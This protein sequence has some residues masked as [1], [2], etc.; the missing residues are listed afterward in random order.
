MAAGKRR[1][2]GKGR[3]PQEPGIP[4]CP[5]GD[6]P[7]PEGRVQGFKRAPLP[8]R[9]LRRS[10]HT[11]NKELCAANEALRFQGEEL[12]SVGAQ[13]RARIK[14]LESANNDLARFF[15]STGIPVLFLDREFNV[16]RFTPA[17]CGLAEFQQ[18]DIGRPLPDLLLKKLGAGLLH[19]AGAV[20]DCPDPRSRK[21]TIGNV[22]YVRT[23]R[24]YRTEDNR[25]EGSV[26]TFVDI[27]GCKAD[28][29][30]FQASE[31]RLR[32]LNDSGLLGVIYWDIDGV[33][34][35]ANDKFLEMVGHSRADLDAGI[36]DWRRLTPPEYRE[37]D[38]LS[39]IELKLTGLNRTSF[40]KE[41][42]RKDGSRI[43]VIV[44]G[45]MLDEER[46]S[47]VAV[48]LDNT[49]RKRAEE[50]L[51]ESEERYR[52]LF[53]TL[54]EGFC[55][56]QMI[57]DSTGKPVDYRYLQ[58]NAAFEKQTGLHEA[59]GKL[60]RDLA[61]NHE[62]HW[63]EIYGTIALTGVRRHFVNQARALNRWFDVYAYRVGNPENRQVAILFNDISGIKGSEEILRSQAA[64]LNQAHDA[65][66]VR[67]TGERI[68][69]WNKGAEAMYGWP[70]REALGAHAHMLLKTRFPRP[71]EEI[72]QE[73]AEKGAW[74]GELIHTCR[75]GREIVVDSRWVAHKDNEGHRTGF[76][77]LNRD[78]TVRKLA[79]EALK[80][81][82]A[83]LEA[84][85]AELDSFNYSV[86]HDL[87]G[88]L[89]AIGAFG[90]MLGDEYR[91]L[92]DGSGKV[93]LEQIF[94][95]TDRMAQLIDDLL[96]LSRITRTEI[97]RTQVDLGGIAKTMAQDLKQ[98]DPER[99]VD[100]VI[101]D[102]VIFADRG[103]MIIVIENLFS[104]AWKF[105]S[106]R[107]HAKIEFSCRQEGSRSVYFVRDNGEGFD[108]AHGRKL[109]TP[110]QRLHANT[111][112][113][114]TGIGLALIRRI[115]ERH[116]GSV[117]AEGEVGKGATIS[118]EIPAA[119]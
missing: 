53:N 2:K 23:A 66:I 105:T 60:M 37:L 42:F 38:D 69:F 85:N 74:E 116:G 86:S 18:S 84:R 49:E 104:N 15:S 65:I 98:G 77:E 68:T 94:R 6:K 33:I 82:N 14:E 46:R 39:M 87:R 95:S 7:V 40:E 115:I 103:L 102:I 1:K 41:Y 114:G 80:E 12:S 24:P 59:Q 22:P 27:S 55:I 51:R 107:L 28:E 67:N 34:S 20:F 47:G 72:A 8:L 3:H 54:E 13:L 78:I 32:R 21:I 10:M 61:P 91:A 75:D 25:I 93:Y 89:R 16:R 11:V 50:A 43:P 58:V 52:N 71:L 113:P 118:F 62:Q 5:T 44:A 117:W 35:D 4:N 109:F 70:S 88:P 99:N 106:R 108:M 57:F 97:K 26:I 36:L 63:F 45:A 76:M 101:D 92:L 90:R 17:L 56:V 31:L 73:V 81:S 64:L 29:Q 79:E 83:L 30:V 111:D 112:F 96:K 9:A 119:F 48:V 19:D 110:F 100:F